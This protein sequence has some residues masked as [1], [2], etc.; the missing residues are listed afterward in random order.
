M[1]NLIKTKRNRISKFNSEFRHVESI[2]FWEYPEESNNEVKISV[3]FFVESLGNI[4]SKEI[5]KNLKE[6][7][8]TLFHEKYFTIT[9]YNK[10]KIS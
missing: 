1:D 4:T 8:K 3:D 6:E 5:V 7:L 9:R 2:K 10:Q